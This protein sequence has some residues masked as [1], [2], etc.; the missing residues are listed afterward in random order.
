MN[1]DKLDDIVRTVL[2]ARQQG[3][4][5]FSLQQVNSVDAHHEVTYSECLARL[6]RLD[7]TVI[8]AGEFIPALEGSGYAP[9][10]DRHIL[11]LAFDWLSNN[12]SGSL[13]CNISTLNLSDA[14]HRALLYEQL[15]RRRSLAPRL[16]LEITESAP[17]AELACAAELIQ[18]IRR[19]G[20]RVAVDDFG[21]G[22]STP[23]ALF[24]MT[25]DIV[26]ID[27]FFVQLNRRPDAERLLHH[28]VGLASCMAP[29][30]VVEGIE[31]YDQLAIARAAGATHVQG[32]L[33]S[34]PT[35]SPIFRGL[36]RPAVMDTGFA[37]GS[38]ALGFAKLSA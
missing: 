9:Q 19:L 8:T 4:I 1:F 24:S 5:G 18:D 7:G 15:Y 21:I 20:Y 29:T 27:A 23:E 13:G 12:A 37:Y 34:E 28:M 35:L 30:I 16:V 14:E 38:K 6:V 17:I 36:E 26:K 10:L 2:Q 31:T 11:N 33:L 22:F 25:V 32:Y 3:R